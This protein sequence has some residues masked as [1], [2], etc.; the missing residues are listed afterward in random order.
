MTAQA[1]TWI[2][3]ARDVSESVVVSG[4]RRTIVA[5][6]L[7]AATGLI[8]NV[9]PGTSSAD[10]LRR[11]LK[12]ALVT[13]AAPL[14]KSVPERLVSAPELLE[15]V[16]TAAASLSKLAAAEITE[17][18]SMDDAE[19]IFDMVVGQMEGRGQPVDPPSV[20]D[21]RDLYDAL[22]AYVDAALWRRWTDSDWFSATLELH[23][24]SIERACLVLGNAGL[25]HGFNAVLDPAMLEL[26]AVDSSAGRGPT[27]ALD[28][29]LVVHL[30]PWRETKGVFADKARRYGW[31]SE[32]RLVPSLLT[33]RDGGP[34]DLSSVDAQLLTL[35]LR[36]VLA[37]DA[38][39]LTVVNADATAATGEVC[40]HDGTVGH[41]RMARPR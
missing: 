36:G 26:L 31:P 28:Q 19:D 15:A 39:R 41:F 11:A 40:F 1:P 18:G 34:A 14:P 21:W 8:V 6:V 20:G 13:P 35:A 23:G 7:D 4:Q 32:A 10:V 33:F 12:G 24:I 5:V 27:Q 22:L 25:Q 16:H 30:D 2:V 9:T 38:R 37:A 29:A 3:L 17:A